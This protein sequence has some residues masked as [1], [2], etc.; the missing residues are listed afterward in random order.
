MKSLTFSGNLYDMLQLILRIPLG[1]FSD[2]IGRRKIFITLGM[3][4]SVISSLVTF[5]ALSSLSLL[6]TRSLAGVTAS[7]W[8]IVTVMF[9]NYFKKKE[10][11]KAIGL[12]NSYYAIG[13]L[14]GMGLV[15]FVSLIFGTIRTISCQLPIQLRSFTI[16]ERLG[17]IRVPSL[18]IELLAV[19]IT[20]L[21][22][23]FSKYNLLKVYL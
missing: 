9:S 20:S 18:S 15:G 3:A 6:I 4:V 13:Q 10:V 19:L 23:N 21:S 7:T 14:V 5:I 16:H 22:Q 2:H 11:T 8:V 17:P 1:I 12:M